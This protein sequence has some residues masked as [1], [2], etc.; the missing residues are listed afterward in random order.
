MKRIRSILFVLLACFA[1]GSR[2]AAQTGDPVEIIGY[3]TLCSFQADAQMHASMFSAYPTAVAYFNGRAEAFGQVLSATALS[4]SSPT[5]R[6]LAGALSL[7]YVSMLIQN[8]PIDAMF[9]LGMSDAF[10]Q[11]ADLIGE[12]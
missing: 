5:Y 8:N 3:E 2:A 9:W 1:F 7:V 6:D 10:N 11:I 12:P 4:P